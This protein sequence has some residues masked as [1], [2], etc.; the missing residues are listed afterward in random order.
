MPFISRELPEFRPRSRDEVGAGSQT[1]VIPM[2]RI[3]TSDESMLLSNNG[4]SASIAGLYSK[5]AIVV[6]KRRSS[7]IGEELTDRNWV[8]ELSII[9]TGSG[10]GN[11]IDLNYLRTNLFEQK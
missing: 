11:K 8:I 7:S 9:T 5:P 4:A 1:L 10:T 3:L 6:L 2:Q